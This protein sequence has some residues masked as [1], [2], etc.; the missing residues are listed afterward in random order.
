M[1]VSKQ[2]VGINFTM[3]QHGGL[4]GNGPVL[5]AWSPGGGTVWEGLEVCP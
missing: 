5:N 2:C 1:E 3:R 4:S